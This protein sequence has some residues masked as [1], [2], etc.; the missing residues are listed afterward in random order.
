MQ[1]HIGVE[2]PHLHSHKCLQREAILISNL[3]Y[4][5]WGCMDV[6]SIKEVTMFPSLLVVDNAELTFRRFIFIGNAALSGG[7]CRVEHHCIVHG[8]T[9]LLD[10]NRAL[11]LYG[12]K[13]HLSYG[14]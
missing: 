1:L 4:F 10:G 12:G 13:A 9:C 3:K 14:N 11:S 2:Q 6:R 5:F 8:G 7:A